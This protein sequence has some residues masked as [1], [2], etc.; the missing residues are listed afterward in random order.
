MEA[1]STGPIQAAALGFLIVRELLTLAAIGLA[2]S[3]VDDLFVDAVYFA[4]RLARW[5]AVRPTHPYIAVEALNSADPGWMAVLI[6]AWDE[7]EVIGATL[8]GLTRTYDYP[9]LSCVR[10]HLSERSSDARGG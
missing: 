9:A 3:G 1:L 4:R 10:R 5:I 6:P 8:T 2:L 7:A